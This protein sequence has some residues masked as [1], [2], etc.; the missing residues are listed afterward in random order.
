[1][2]ELQLLVAIWAFVILGVVAQ[3]AIAM[4]E[5]KDFEWYNEEVEDNEYELE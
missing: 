5:A 4:M 2:T 1:M 3:V